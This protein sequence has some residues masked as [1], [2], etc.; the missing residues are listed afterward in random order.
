[1]FSG[2][3]IPAVSAPD[4]D[5][6]DGSYSP[7]AK[8]GRTSPFTQFPPTHSGNPEIYTWKIITDFYSTLSPPSVQ[9]S[10]FDTL[11]FPFCSF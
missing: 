8:R 3:L 7:A 10:F 5:K 2:L 4:S 1:M 6:E 9:P 11:S